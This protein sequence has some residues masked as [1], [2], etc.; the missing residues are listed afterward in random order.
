MSRSSFSFL[1]S[2]GDIVIQKVI[3]S[4]FPSLKVIIRTIIPFIATYAT[5]KMH[6]VF[7]GGQ[8]G[9]FAV[10]VTSKI[11]QNNIIMKR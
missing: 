5:F 7:N 6:V 4:K 3:I 10:K 11:K 1:F 8:W 9:P 2:C